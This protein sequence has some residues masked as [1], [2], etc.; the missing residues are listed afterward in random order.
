M[1]SPQP[2]SGPKPL[3]Q[4]KAAAT[5]V[6][7]SAKAAVTAVGDV[8][9]K[10][11]KTTM[12]TFDRA[13]NFLD[14][15]IRGA[16]NGCAKWG[17]WGVKLG[18][19]AGIAA[20]LLPAGTILAGAISGIGL[21]FYGALAGGVVGAGLGLV[22]GALTGG[23]ERL[24]LENRKEK[25]ATQLEERRQMRSPAPA[26]GIS[27]KR[28]DRIMDHIDRVTYDKIDQYND[29]RREDAGSWAD[30]VDASRANASLLER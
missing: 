13:W 4:A 20:M 25:Y 1:A 16:L 14:G 26:R 3:D 8:A 22:K 10:V 28:Y 27:N 5:A 30:R 11:S 23:T 12:S 21:P 15:T 24:A 17:R 18:V 6:G 19:V 7:D 29:R 2:T 9:T